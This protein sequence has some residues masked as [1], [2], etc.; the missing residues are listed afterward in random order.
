MLYVYVYWKIF[1]KHT[2]NTHTHTHTRHWLTQVSH[3]C[4]SFSF[5]SLQY[6][7]FLCCLFWGLTD[8]WLEERKWRKIAKQK[9][10]FCAND[11]RQHTTETTTTANETETETKMNK[12]KSKSKLNKCSFWIINKNKGVS[13]SLFYRYY[14]LVHTSMHRGRW[15]R[16]RIWGK[17]LCSVCGSCS[18]DWLVLA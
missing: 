4:D 6:L 15:G 10:N 3:L 9:F 16:G 2:P 11:K 13:P 7:L 5:L 8:D 18:F 12:N 17:Y 1:A 14:L